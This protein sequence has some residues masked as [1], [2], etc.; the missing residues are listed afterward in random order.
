MGEIFPESFYSLSVEQ[1]DHL[2]FIKASGFYLSW[3]STVYLYNIAKIM[4]HEVYYL[5][6]SE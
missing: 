4:V 2:F 3:F 1:I 6:G 5:V